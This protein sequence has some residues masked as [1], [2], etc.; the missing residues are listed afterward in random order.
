MAAA[1]SAVTLPLLFEASWS[2]RA[3]AFVAFVKPFEDLF[4]RRL[5]GFLRTVFRLIRSAF[6]RRRLGHDFKIVDDDG[7]DG[8][9][10]VS[11]LILIFILI[12][13]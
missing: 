5:L 6:R 10:F 4:E 8:F 3:H 2:M 1:C 9:A 12:H 7:H 13:S 11:V